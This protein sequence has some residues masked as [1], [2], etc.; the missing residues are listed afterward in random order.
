MRGPMF[1]LGPEQAVRAHLDVRG[2]TMVPVHW[3]TFNLAKHAW[4][5]PVERILVAAEQEGVTVFTFLNLCSK[6]KK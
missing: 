6:N 2:K 5:E 3:G 1:I 4:T